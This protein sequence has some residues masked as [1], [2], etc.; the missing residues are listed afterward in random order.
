MNAETETTLSII[1]SSYLR[2]ENIISAVSENLNCI[3]E[4][5]RNVFAEF[6]TQTQYINASIEH[7]LAGMKRHV[8]NNVFREW[9]DTMIL[10]QRDH[11]MKS[12]LEPTIAKLSDMRLVQSELNTMLYKPIRDFVMMAVTA[13]MTIPIL[14]FLNRAWFDNLFLTMAGKISLAVLC[15]AL[16]YSLQSL[17][18]AVKP[19]EYKR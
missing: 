8:D 4:P 13:L 17:I 15:V 16:L 5:L 7:A 12:M 10:C 11:T 14:F 2:T 18:K 6:L 9:C 1:T 19:L 3:H